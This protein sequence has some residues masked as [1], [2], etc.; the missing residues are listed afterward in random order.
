MA[1]L[2]RKVTIRRK[3]APKEVKK[4]KWWIWII[5]VVILLA[6]FFI[7]KNITSNRTDKSLIAKTEQA[8]TKAND[9]I[10]E[11]QSGNFNFEE[12]K[13][14]VNEAQKAVDEAKANAKTDEEKQNVAKAQ[15]KVNEAFSV[16]E[17]SEQSTNPS[18]TYETITQDQQEVD[19]KKPIETSTTGQVTNEKPVENTSNVANPNSSNQKTNTKSSSSVTI[20]E[21][22][23]EQKA[24]DVIKGIYGNGA[25]RKNALGSEYNSIQSRVNEMYR[26]GEIK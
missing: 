2:K 15:A 22:T 20:P 16:V 8:I 5:I 25:D 19:T 9:V 11:V 24:K 3:E 21:E 4:S 7:I 23:L 26:N 18:E 1:E 10:A 6:S 12:T 14:K 13:A 17:N